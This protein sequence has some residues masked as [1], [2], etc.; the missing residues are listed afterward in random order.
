MVF[1]EFVIVV[2]AKSKRVTLKARAGDSEA[3]KADFEGAIQDPYRQALD[4][5]ARIQSGAKCI[6]KDGTELEFHSLPA[7]LP[8]GC[9]KRP[10][11]GLDN[12]LS[13][14]A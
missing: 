7:L 8:D 4:C 10:I 3:L 5:V 14:Y 9:V 2:Q 12:T 13:R 6:A 1:G 11:S